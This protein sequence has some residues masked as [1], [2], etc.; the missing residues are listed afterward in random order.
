MRRVLIWRHGETEQNAAGIYQGQLDTSLSARG[1]EQAATA[2]Q[3]LAQRSPARLV[4]SDLTRAATT[5]AALASAS[6]LTVEP[7]RR[8]REI[9]VGRWQGLTHPEVRARFP[10]L[11][12]ELEQ[13]QDV[14]RGETGER[15]RDVARRMRAVFDEVVATQEQDSTVVLASHG[16]ASRALVADVLGMDFTRLTQA[17]VGL[18]NC[19]WAELV[20][21]DIGWRLDAW[22]TGA[23]AATGR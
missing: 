10:E 16:L 1:R 7:D 14:R 3:L 12:A 13:G 22:N 6:G 20:E 8:L 17:L 9:D 5:A 2:A 23:P 15:V 11:Q 18:H 19:H 4:A 21:H